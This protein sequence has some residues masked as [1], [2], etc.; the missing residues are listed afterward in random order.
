MRNLALVLAVF[1]GGCLTSQYDPMG[2]G[3][4]MNNGN[5]GSGGGGGA[6]GGGGSAGG[7]GVGGAGGAGGAGGGGGGSGLSG[8]ITSNQTWDGM[9]QI[10]GSISIEAGA[11]V[12]VAAGAL[13]NVMPGANISVKGTLITQGTAASPATFNTMQQGS[14]WGGIIVQAGGT[15]NLSYANIEYTTVPF[16]C[17]TGA[18]QC[19]ADHTQLLNFTGVG[20]SLTESATFSYMRVEFGGS[21]GISFQG[22]AGQTVTITDSTFHQTGGDAIVADGAGN[23]VFQYNHVYGN[24]GATPGQ[25][26]ACHFDSTGTFTVDHNLFEQSSV[27]FMASSMDAQSKVMYNNFENN[28]SIYS[29]AGGTNVSAQA[30]LSHNYWGSSTPPAIPGNTTNQGTAGTAYY[31]TAIATGIGPR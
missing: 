15:A 29:S 22:S 20:M 8:S 12:T 5:G 10:G 9:V 23:L 18:A 24:G 26:C 11:T 13:V 30:D 16:S 27:G 25:H 2:G 21:D 31:A 19:K 3:N 6:G 17:V 4:M 14:S 7:G 1:V 28:P